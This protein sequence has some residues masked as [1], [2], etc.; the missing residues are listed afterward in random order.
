MAKNSTTLLTLLTCLIPLLLVL[1][2]LSLSHGGISK[3][4]GTQDESEQ[5]GYVEVRPKCH[6][7]WWIYRSPYRVEDPSKPWPIILWLQGG[8]G[9]SGVGTGNF[10][11]VG[12]LDTNLSPRNS[13]W[14]RKAD[15]LFVDN[16][17]GS[18]FSYVEKI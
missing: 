2:S 13:T 6:M 12:P 10:Q 8:P 18:G 7:F 4:S 9:A 3:T 1:S 14:L 16:P 17:V 5:W 11:E 15:L